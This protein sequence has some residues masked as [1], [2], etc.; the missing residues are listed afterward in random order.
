MFSSLGCPGLGT[1]PVQEEPRFF[2]FFCSFAAEPKS[3]GVCRAWTT[4]PQTGAGWFQPCKWTRNPEIFISSPAGLVPKTKQVTQNGAGWPDRPC[5]GPKTM[6]GTQMMQWN[7]KLLQM[8][9]G[10]RQ[11]Q[12]SAARGVVGSCAPASWCSDSAISCQDAGR[13]GNQ[14]TVS[15]SRKGSAVQGDAEN[16]VGDGWA[17][18]SKVVSCAVFALAMTFEL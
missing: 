1:P 4:G 5:R 8:D 17:S 18:W 3:G 12:P 11:G 7:L 15:Y 9:P 14:S 2:H 16:T 13:R 6:Q 10:P